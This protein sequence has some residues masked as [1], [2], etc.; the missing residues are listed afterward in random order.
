MKNGSMLFDWYV[1]EFKDTPER[2]RGVERLL[3]Q[4]HT[5]LAESAVV[6]A[7]RGRYKRQ[8]PAGIRV[9]RNGESFVI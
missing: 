3:R 7:L 9:N 6:K 4:G 5:G 8:V 2:V 1:E